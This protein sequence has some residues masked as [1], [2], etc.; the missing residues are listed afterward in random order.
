MFRGFREV[1]VQALGKIRLVAAM[2]SWKM[3]KRSSTD[4]IGNKV[5][6]QWIRASGKRG[7][8]DFNQFSPNFAIQIF[9]IFRNFP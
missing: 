5:F 1:A 6:A 2:F 8:C 4:C 9:R 7:K 3:K